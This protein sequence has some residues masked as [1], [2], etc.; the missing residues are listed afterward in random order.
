MLN[1]KLNDTDMRSSDTKDRNTIC[2]NV[3]K[4]NKQDLKLP[5]SR[6]ADGFSKSIRSYY[7]MDLGLWEYGRVAKT[8]AKISL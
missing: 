4:W 3:S 7:L 5:G 8:D 2:Q 1:L 6:L